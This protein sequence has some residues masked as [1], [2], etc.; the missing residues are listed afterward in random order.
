M[1]RR[2]G[3]AVALWL[4]MGSM[5]SASGL[6][7]LQPV[8][9]RYT[10]TLPQGYGAAAVLDVQATWQAERIVLGGKVLTARDRTALQKRFEP[11][12][13]VENRIEVFPYREVGER[14]Y[15]AVRVPVADLRAEPK[16]DSGL[17]SQLLMGDTVKV[18]AAS[19]DRQWLKV[20]RE[21][22]SYVGW[23]EVSA[24]QTWTRQEYTR[25]Q[26]LPKI[27]LLR[28]EQGLPRAALLVAPMG[29]AA[30]PPRSGFDA[31]TPDGQKLF[32]PTSAAHLVTLSH[33][34]ERSE[35]V[36]Y[37]RMLLAD[38]PT[39]YVWGGTAGRALDCSG[40]NQT[41]FRLAGTVLPRDAYQ[42]QAASRPTA[43]RI[44]DWQQLQ[45]GDLVFFSEN[46]RR[47]THTGIYVGDGKYI[48]SSRGNDGI[49]INDL[50]GQSEYD[51]KLKRLWWGAGSVLP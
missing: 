42:Q 30:A 26:A 37:A 46:G 24:L 50:T 35:V 40:F 48:H 16:N 1:A 43:T 31:L 38:Q 15:G 14:S 36:R 7:D 19:P 9:N 22:D 49:A 5:L 3:S 32:L 21:W 10:E 29:V 11:L 23:V 6:P 4:W 28:S 27:M 25:W 13:P 47:A 51:L 34:V 20:L 33:R 17:E 8:V 44:E 12:G 45:P 41:V 39:H 18:L 2:L